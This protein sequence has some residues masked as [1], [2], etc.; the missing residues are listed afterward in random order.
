MKPGVSPSDLAVLG[1]VPHME[2][3]RSETQTTVCVVLAEV[4]KRSSTLQAIFAR[5][6][7]VGLDLVGL[8]TVH[9][10]ARHA[11]AGGS[12]LVNDVLSASPAALSS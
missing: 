4:L 10:D 11:Q 1:R 6:D 8:R 12:P 3:Q 2:L 5:I 9:I 7:E